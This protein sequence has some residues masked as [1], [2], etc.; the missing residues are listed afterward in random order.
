[1]YCCTDLGMQVEAA[2]GDEGLATDVADEVPLPSVTAHVD[3]QDGRRHEEL[4]TF[5]AL[6]LLGPLPDTNKQ[7]NSFS[8]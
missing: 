6:V 1:M 2:Q 8:P 5:L 7:N 3:G 4:A